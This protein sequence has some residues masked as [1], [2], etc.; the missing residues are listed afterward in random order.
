[1]NKEADSE[2]VTQNTSNRK[3]KAH[4]MFGVDGDG[5]VIPDWL[6]ILLNEGD[7]EYK[8]EA[9]IDLIDQFT[10]LEERNLFLINQK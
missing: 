2:S 7:I 1:M 6:Q 5:Y 4:S 10:L 9:T 8:L 3:K